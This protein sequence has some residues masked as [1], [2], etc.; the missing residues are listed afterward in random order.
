MSNREVEISGEVR[1]E[2]VKAYLWWD[3]KVEAWVPK[4]QISDLTEAQRQ[5]AFDGAEEYFA[6]QDGGEEGEEDPMA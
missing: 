6:A 1:R 3:G 4:S 2:T 5:E